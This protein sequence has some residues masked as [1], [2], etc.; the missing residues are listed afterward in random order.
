MNSAQ[1]R[2]TGE[3]FLVG[4]RNLCRQTQEVLSAR[5]TP[6]GVEIPGHRAGLASIATCV[7][8]AQEALF[9]ARRESGRRWWKPP[10]E[11]GATAEEILDRVND[12][13]TEYRKVY[14]HS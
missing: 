2:E 10:F 11:G 3:D 1:E 5:G 13:T 4:G 9:R 14:H 12:W 8:Q 6:S 7:K